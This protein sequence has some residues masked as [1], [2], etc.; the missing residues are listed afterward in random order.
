MK[1]IN[2]VRS[3]R[4]GTERKLLIG[5]AGYGMVVSQSIMETSK[6]KLNAATHPKRMR[7][8]RA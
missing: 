2:Q 5:Y 7:Q 3:V 8:R 1:E 4:R 6:N